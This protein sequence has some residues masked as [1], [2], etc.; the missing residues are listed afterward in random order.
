MDDAVHAPQVRPEGRPF[1]AELDLVEFD[2]RWRIVST[3]SARACSLS[4][5]N[6]VVRSRRMVYRNTPIGVL[7]H[8]IDDAPV[9]LLT[10][11][12]HCEYDGDGMY[13]V[14]LDLV[15]IPESGP[16]AVWAKSQR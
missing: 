9:P 13:R 14:D 4:R 6:I 7:I 8:L 10:R 11:S 15:P 5:S 3:W 16:V 1:S 12:Y 2:E